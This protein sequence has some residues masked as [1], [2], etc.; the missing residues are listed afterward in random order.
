[1]Q[2]PPSLCAIYNNNYNTCTK[3]PITLQPMYP[4]GNRSLLRF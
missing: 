3:M 4:M 2:C 1:M